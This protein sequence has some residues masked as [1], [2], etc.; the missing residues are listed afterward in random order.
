MDRFEKL[1]DDAR[2]L[3]EELVNLRNI[4]KSLDRVK[5][6]RRERLEGGT[7][8]NFD[9]DDDP[10]SF[11]FAF[12]NAPERLEAKLIAKGEEVITAVKE[13][14]SEMHV[15]MRKTQ[16][17]VAN[18]EL[19]FRL[20]QE[21]YRKLELMNRLTDTPGGFGALIDERSSDMAGDRAGDDGHAE[22]RVVLEEVLR[23]W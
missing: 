11:F 1:S 23:E 21:Y 4:K 17:N 7:T 13:I 12:E 15:L 19:N 10:L 3:L 9:D 16:T 18:R 6:R 8:S 5:R 20:G 22:R 2:G 14:L